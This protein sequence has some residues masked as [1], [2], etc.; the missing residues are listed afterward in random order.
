MLFLYF[1]NEQI[2][3]FLLVFKSSNYK[4]ILD[5]S[6]SQFAGFLVKPNGFVQFL[7]S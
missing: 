7:E 1:E 3:N 6:P 5:Q 2:S 4:V